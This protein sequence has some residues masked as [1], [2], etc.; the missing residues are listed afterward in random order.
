MGAWEGFHS[1]N[2]DSCICGSTLSVFI[3]DFVTVLV[4]LR[5]NLLFVRLGSP[6]MVLSRFSLVVFSNSWLASEVSF[7]GLIV[8]IFVDPLD[9]FQI[10]FFFQST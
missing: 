5:E 6:S 9:S 3:E 4:S 1:A 2:T 7:S 10:F 8:S